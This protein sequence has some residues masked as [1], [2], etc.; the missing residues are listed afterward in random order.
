MNVKNISLKMKDGEY[1]A[2]VTG[3]T[4]NSHNEVL[5]QNIRSNSYTLEVTLQER[6]TP[7]SEGKV[8]T[9]IT[10]GFRVYARLG[11]LRPGRY[12]VRVNGNND[13][14]MWFNAR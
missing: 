11:Q 1:Y 10:G 2:E 4:S 6:P 9:Q 7:S 14:V 12:A 5:V 3:G 8:T 13:W